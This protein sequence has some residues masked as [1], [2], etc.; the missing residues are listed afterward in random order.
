[1]FKTTASDFFQLCRVFRYLFLLT[2][3]K[4]SRETNILFTPK[5][6]LFRV[7]FWHNDEWPFLALHIPLKNNPTS[8]KMYIA[9]APPTLLTHPYSTLYLYMDKMRY[10]HH[11]KYSKLKP[12]PHFQR[13]TSSW[14]PRGLDAAE[15]SNVSI[16][17]VYTKLRYY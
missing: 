8:H 6:A 3:I 2:F 13:K 15:S 4:I 5:C 7:L 16:G 14:S 17:C 1:M 9:M 11:G 10:C 12:L